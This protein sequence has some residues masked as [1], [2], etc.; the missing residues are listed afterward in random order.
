MSLVT[1][2]TDAYHRIGDT[3]INLITGLG[4]AKDPRTSSHFVF[5]ELDRHILE[6]MYRSDWLARRIVDLPAQDATREWRQWSASRPQLEKIDLLE[7]HL[8]VQNKM[9]MGLIRARLYGGGALVLGVDQGQPEE[10][11]DLDG[12]GLNDLKFVVV[13]N[14]Y[15]LA[16]GPRIYNV[17]SPY[18]TRPE[19]YTVATPMFGF[20]GEGGGA[21]PATPSQGGAPPI[22]SDPG[23]QVQPGYGMV[24]VH[25]SRVI[26]FSGNELPD[27]RLAP[28]GGGWGDS[29]LQTVDDALRDFSMITAGLASMVNDMK[30]DVVKIPEL[31]SKLSTADRTQLLLKRFTAANMAKSSINTLLLDTEE[32]WNRITTSFGSTP[33]LIKVAMTVACGAGGI[34]ESRVMGSSPGKGLAGAGGSGGEV[35]ILNYNNDIASKQKTEYKPIMYALD[36]CITQSAIGRYDPH[37]DYE[38]NPLSRPTAAELADVAL[39]KAQATQIYVASGLFNEDMLRDS[40]ISQLTEDNVYPGME[41]ALDEHGAEPE[42]PDVPPQGTMPQ[43]QLGSNPFEALKGQAAAKAGLPPPG[44]KQ[45]P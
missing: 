9:R 19:Y 18:Y 29:V 27:W 14:R 43:G 22:L 30:M 42:E 24:R 37:I 20:F 33:E 8:Q 13:V 11:L 12:V 35:D 26:E 3:L 40:I 31:T 15:E 21:F 38:W 34:P 6:K 44:G 16:A 4:T 25:P 10:E 23:R 28:L 7:K 45:T 5:R 1:G 32:E 39:K 41:N 17:D 36:R 2:V